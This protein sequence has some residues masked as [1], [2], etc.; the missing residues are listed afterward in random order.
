MIND[1]LRTRDRRSCSILLPEKIEAE[2]Q[3]K[4]WNGQGLEKDEEGLE[5]D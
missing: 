5:K 1:V 4:L 2:Q 3:V